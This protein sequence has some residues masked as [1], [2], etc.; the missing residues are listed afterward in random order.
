MKALPLLL[1]AAGLTTAASAQS[2]PTSSNLPIVIV[3]TN[4]Q[5]IADEPKI[6]ADMGII[7]NGVGVRNNIADSLN[8]YNG[9]IGIEFRGNSSQN[10]PKKPYSI[11]TRKS[12]STNLDVSLLGLPAEN[13]WILY[14]TYDDETYMRD[15][16]LHTLA[17]GVGLYSPRT[18]FVELFV[19]SNDTLE[20]EDHRGVYVLM[21]KIK[22]DKN[23]V[24]ISKLEYKD[25]TGNALTGGYILKIDHHAGNPGPVWESE[26]PN[27]CGDFRTD[28]ELQEPNDEDLHPAHLAYIKDY[29]HQF[30]AALHGPDF[31]DP[32]RGFRKYA[33][34][35]SF[36]YYFL[37][38]E[39]ARSTDAY[40]FSTY[41]YKNRDSKGGKLTMGPLWDYNSSMGNAPYNFCAANDIVGWQY[42]A[43]RICRV[44]RKPPFWWKRLMDDP[45]F[46]LKVQTVWQNLRDNSL[47]I[48][49]INAMIEENLSHV[50]EAQPRDYERW[51]TIGDRGDFPTEI[52]FLKD[53]LAQRMNWMDE[54]I[55]LLGNFIRSPFVIEPITCEKSVP[56]ATYTG[57]QLTYQWKLD[58]MPLPGATQSNI[59]AT[60]PGTY[61]VAVTLADSCYTETLTTPALSRIVSSQQSGNW[62]TPDTWECGTIPTALD[63]VIVRT[64]HTISLDGTGKALS[65]QLESDARIVQQA[66]TELNIGH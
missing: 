57:K 47:K 11:E 15:V 24:D 20:Y 45:A 30:E 37:L 14:N 52:A 53:W 64:N 3:K 40:S 18:V 12:D 59:M 6:M 46:V 33:D 8:H 23:R 36:A 1:L 25:S 32:E 61:S 26:Y 39:L 56:L 4:G 19:T 49:A 65:L 42:Q 21:E 54:N 5:S 22:R 41:M 16:L 66:N 38:S 51:N 28:F 60:M 43:Q 50:A 48:T 55:P 7:Y 10:S 63:E 62:Q 9:K 29:I 44:D 34:E 17:R 58:G 27:E 2:I 35:E 13:D 31:A